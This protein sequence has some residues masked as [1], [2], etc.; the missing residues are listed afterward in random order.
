MLSLVTMKLLIPFFSPWAS[1]HP[2]CTG[3][4]IPLCIVIP[5]DLNTLRDMSGDLSTFLQG[6][7]TGTLSVG[8]SLHHLVHVASC[9]RFVTAEKVEQGASP[10]K[11][12]GVKA[13]HHPR[14][15]EWRYRAI[16]KVRPST[17][18]EPVD[19]RR[20]DAGKR[21]A[22]NPASRLACRVRC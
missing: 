1:S 7:K 18:S 8:H 9:M 14:S 16:Q 10:I 22:G 21:I 11:Q 2:R 19:F 20:M 5:W 3:G 15:F 12:S 13:S 6:T 4:A 17:L